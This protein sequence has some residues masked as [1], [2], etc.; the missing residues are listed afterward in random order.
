V[1]IGGAMEMWSED[2]PWW[3]LIISSALIAISM[4][5]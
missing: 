2:V 5:V 3:V 4:A 1:P